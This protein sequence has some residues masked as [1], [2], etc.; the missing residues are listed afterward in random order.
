M[1]INKHAFTLIEL[2]VVVLIIGIL[3]AIALPQYQKAVQKTRAAQLLILVK[4]FENA[5]ALYHLAT[6]KYADSFDQLDITLDG[7]SKPSA[8]TF[9][10]AVTSTDAV[11]KFDNFEIILDNLPD[12]TIH[13]VMGVNI[14]GKYKGSS[15]YYPFVHSSVP[16][17]KLY[18]LE[19]RRT[20]IFSQPE[21]SYC[22]KIAGFDVFTFET[23]GMRYYIKQ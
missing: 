21:G 5:Q 17:H 2:L 20:N 11:R 16:A 18:C 14:T 4:N 7:A 8:S 3:A 10:Y 9:G 22:Q 12:G 23:P 6:N 19:D 13:T 15:F 1:Y